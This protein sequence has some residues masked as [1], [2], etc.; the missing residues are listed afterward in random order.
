MTSTMRATNASSANK[1]SCGV[2]GKGYKT[3]AWLKRHEATHQKT[4]VI[5]S[6]ISSLQAPSDDSEGIQTFVCMCLSREFS[7]DRNSN[8]NTCMSMYEEWLN[9]H[10]IYKIRE[11]LVLG[12]CHYHCLIL[13]MMFRRT[14]SVVRL[15]N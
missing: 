10:I 9:T 12:V 13:V 3:E 11:N 2:C 7:S 15:F 8:S 5:T 4:T 1:Y 14:N 6:D